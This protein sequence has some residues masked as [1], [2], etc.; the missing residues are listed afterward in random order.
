[1]SNDWFWK[2]WLDGNDDIIII[3]TIIINSKA[4]HIQQ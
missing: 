1:M 2:D 3:I 4:N